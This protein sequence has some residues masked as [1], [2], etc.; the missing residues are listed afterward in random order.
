MLCS[1]SRSAFWTRYRSRRNCK[2]IQKS[3]D[4][5]KNLANRKAV[6][7]VIPLRPLIISFIR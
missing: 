6:L 3:G 7:G 1:S 5:P 4:K 2:F